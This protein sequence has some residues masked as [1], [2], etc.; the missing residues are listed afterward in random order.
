MP[1]AEPV[2]RGPRRRKSSGLGTA[3]AFLTIIPIARSET[4][5]R[6]VSFDRAAAFFPVVGAVLGFVGIFCVWAAQG[7][8]QPLPLAVLCVAILA[9]ASGG[10]HLDGLADTFDAIGGARGDGTRALEILRDPRCG[11]H[12]AAALVFVIMLKIAVVAQVIESGALEILV[13]SPAASRAAVVPLLAWFAPARKEG[14]GAALR[15]ATDRRDVAVSACF[16]V[17]F[18]F[19]TGA[20]TAGRM[21]PEFAGLAAAYA[22]SL[23]LAGLASRRLGGLTGDVDGASVE[24]AEVAFLVV[25]CATGG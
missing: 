8:L 16:A 9:I 15:T 22:T 11:A 14:L 13:V 12:G 3:F 21:G 25:A 7:S 6:S 20:I 1:D 5:P 17:V 19:S 23:G 18:V 4:E 10:L 24:L 2:R